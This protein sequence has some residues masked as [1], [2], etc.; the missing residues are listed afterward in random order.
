MLEAA[1]LDAALVLVSAPAGSGK[2][3]AVSGWVA[4]RDGGGAWYSLDVEDNDPA[5]FWPSIAAALHLDPI[6]T[7]DARIAIAVE[8]STGRG[9]RRL[10]RRQQLVI[11]AGV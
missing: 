7:P 2:S 5:L 9:A 10:P 6:D 1:V 11:H 4:R 8:Q 3:S